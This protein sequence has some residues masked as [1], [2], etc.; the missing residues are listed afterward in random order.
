MDEREIGGVYHCAYWNYIY[1]VHDIDGSQVLVESICEPDI[2]S[3]NVGDIWT[4]RTALDK[5]DTFL[6]FL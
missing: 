6:G 5:R 1:I 2:G 3:N 4:H